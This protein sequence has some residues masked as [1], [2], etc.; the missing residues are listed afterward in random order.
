MIYVPT[1]A[2]SASSE[3]SEPVLPSVPIL[4]S[5]PNPRP[6]REPLRHMLLGSREGVDEAVKQLHLLRYA[7]QFAWSRAIVI[8]ETG[9]LITPNQGDVLRYWV[10]WRSINSNVSPSG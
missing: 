1:F 9:I 3:T 7:E 2:S 5:A 4:L 6:G 8:P 10:Q